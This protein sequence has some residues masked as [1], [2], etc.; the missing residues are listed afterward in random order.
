MMTHKLGILSAT[1]VLGT[2]L[3][4]WAASPEGPRGRVTLPERLGLSSDQVDAWRKLRSDQQKA[5]VQRRADRQKLQIELRD[6]LSAPTLDEA[7][8]RAKARQLGELQAAAMRERVEGRL[9]LR[10][11][12]TPEQAEKLRDAGLERQARRERWRRQRTPRGAHAGDGPDPDGLRE[13]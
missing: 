4:A 8:V 9:A 1:L 2:G 7:A 12:L 5:S 10:K 13:R 11:L 3:A 6:L